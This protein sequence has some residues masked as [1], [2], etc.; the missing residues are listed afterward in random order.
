[1]VTEVWKD[2]QSFDLLQIKLK[3]SCNLTPPPHPGRTADAGE[4][5]SYAADENIIVA[6]PRTTVQQK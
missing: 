2:V 5:Q 3:V 6:S 1:M 4:A